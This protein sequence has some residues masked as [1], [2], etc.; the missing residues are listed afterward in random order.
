MRKYCHLSLL[1]REKLFAWREAGIALRE[2]ARRL[3]RSDSSLGREVKRHTRHWKPYLPC[4]AQARTERVGRRQRSKA[5]LKEPLIYLYVRE[6]LRAGWSPEAVAGRLTVDYPDKTINKETIYRYVYARK[7]SREKLWQY[8]TLA[9]KKRMKKAGRRVRRAGKI[10]EAISI[11]LRPKE[12]QDRQALGHW[13]TD[14]LEGR[15]SDESALSVTV[16]RKTRVTLLSKL[17]ARK[18]VNK[19]QALVSRLSRLPPEARLTLTADNGKENTPHRLISEKL[20]LNVFFC[21]AFHSWEKGTVEN[22]NGRIR[23]YLPKHTSLD[24]LTEEGVQVLEGRLNN[25][26]RKCLGFLT[27]NEEMAKLLPAI[28]YH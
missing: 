18:A 8:L 23:R 24:P 12:V 6:H 15:R 21:H 19:A 5:P 13:E 10:P 14:N 1:E 2:I 27:P 17:E 25:T 20:G 28:S 9:R 22:M 11:D 7:N 3:D 26:P 4:L 16:E